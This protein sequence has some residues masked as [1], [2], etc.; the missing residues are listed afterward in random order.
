MVPVGHLKPHP[1]NPNDHPDDQIPRLAQILEYQGWRYP[2]KVSNLSGFITSGHGRLQAAIH[3][4]QL[5]VPVDFQ[6]YD[7]P[8]QEYADVVADNAIAEWARLSMAKINVEVPELGPDFNFDFLGIRNFVLDPA[9]K[10]GDP[11]DAPETRKVAKTLPGELWILGRHRLLIG[12]ATKPED[13]TRLMGTSR[14]D[15]VFTDPPYNVNYESKAGKIQ[16]DSMDDEAFLG[17]LQAAFTAMAEQMKPGASFYIAHA[18]SEGFN[19]RYATKLAGLQVRQCLIWVKSALV[20]GRQDYQWKHE[21]ILYGWKD[22]AAHNWFSDR[23]QTTTLEFNKPRNNAL[24][25]TMKPVELVAYCLRNSC[26]A[27][28][29]VLDPF[30]GSGTTLMA[31]ES[32]GYAC[33]GT[34]LDPIYADVILERWAKYTNLDPVREDGVKWSVLNSLGN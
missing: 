17:F 3:A 32:L 34:E 23:S 9:E 13:L 30:L 10:P 1:K 16:N 14:A 7:G 20:M 19:F 31:A 27:K 4:N 8:E 33:H 2:I 29:L 18:D 26:P 12:D 22:G 24:H 28:G 15:M 11:D 21:P 25:P 5:E 6:D